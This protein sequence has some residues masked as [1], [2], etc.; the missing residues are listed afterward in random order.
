MNCVIIGSFRKHYKNIVEIIKIFEAGNINV[1][2]PQKSNIINEADEFVLFEYDNQ[3]LLPEE[4]Q[5]YTFE[6][7]FKCD[8]IYVCN[9][10]AYVGKTTCYEIGVVSMYG[11]PIFFQNKPMDL[12]YPNIKN[13][14]TSPTELVEYIKRNGNLPELSINS[15]LS[16]N[17]YTSFYG[18]LYNIGKKVYEKKT[19]VI[20]GSMTF[21]DK[22]V[23][24][25]D[26]L[27]KNNIHTII[28]EEENEFIKN[29]SSKE[30]NDFKRKASNRYLSKIR[31]KGV[32]GV[33][34]VN[35]EKKGKANYIGANTLVEIAMAF[36]WNRHIFLL[37]DVYKPLKDE[38]I[39]WNATVL[40]GNL[41]EMITTYKKD[42]MSSI[43]IS[44]THQ[45][46][47]YDLD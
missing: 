28:P 15:Y 46:S 13:S 29:F 7:M 30:F 41:N 34:V 21:H 38:L 35:E 43:A 1:L 23:E 31:G 44:K 19:I 33:L 14:I 24:I 2:S 32:Y 11:L 42:S 40:K 20:C 17:V 45:I 8:F 9:P 27:V 10:N 22:M 47:I 25:R 5:M 12:P 4:I 18:G 16:K 36:C 39:A 3:A 37:N 6:K 26:L